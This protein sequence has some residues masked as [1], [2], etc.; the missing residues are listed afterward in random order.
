[1]SAGQRGEIVVPKKLSRGLHSFPLFHALFGERG[2]YIVTL[3]HPLA[4][5]RSVLDKSGGM[6]AG[7]RFALRSSI[8]RW[9]L[10]DWL[11]RGAAEDRIRK[12]SYV[13]VFLG[14]WKR[15]HFQIAMDAIPTCA[16]VQ[17]IV[18]GSAN[19]R[20][21]A[22]KFYGGFGSHLAPEPFKQAPE[23]GFDARDQRK[24]EAAVHEVADFWQCLGLEFPLKAVLEGK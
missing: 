4:M 20:R 2:Q 1:M 11:K 3:R 16:G 18:H 9:A 7:N 22:K 6:P 10:D 21:A 24:S 23:P 8:E 13:D 17:L 14:Y 15:C 12:M 19:M 5:I